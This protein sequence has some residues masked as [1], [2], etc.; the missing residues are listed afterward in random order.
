[1]YKDKRIENLRCPSSDKFSGV[2]LTGP[3]YYRNWR[4]YFVSLLNKTETSTE[5]LS[6]RRIR[7][8]PWRVKHFCVWERA[9]EREREGKVVFQHQ[10]HISTPFLSSGTCS[11]EHSQMSGHLCNNWEK[12]RILQGKIGWVHSRRLPHYPL[13]QCWRILVVTNLFSKWGSKSSGLLPRAVG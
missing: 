6:L 8:V 2:T 4:N 1:M 9:K 13:W 10:Q 12:E 11:P 3:P 5:K 7:D